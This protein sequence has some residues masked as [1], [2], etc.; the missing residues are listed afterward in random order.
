MLYR[1]IQRIKE[2]PFSIKAPGNIS[3]GYMTKEVQEA[4]LAKGIPVIHNDKK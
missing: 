3:H 4:L 1:E 2:I